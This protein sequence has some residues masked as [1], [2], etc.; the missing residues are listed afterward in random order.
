MARL[1]KRRRCRVHFDPRRHDSVAPRRHDYFHALVDDHPGSLEHVLLDGMPS[2]GQCSLR[3]A[4][5]PLTEAL[6]P[7]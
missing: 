5:D 1:L 4:S 6:E 3:C 7:G 2:S